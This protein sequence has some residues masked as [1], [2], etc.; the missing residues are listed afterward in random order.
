MSI[1][2]SHAFC[3]KIENVVLYFV[4]QIYIQVLLAYMTQCRHKSQVYIVGVYSVFI[5][6]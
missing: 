2:S 5:E 4:D 6:S 3:V 1:C